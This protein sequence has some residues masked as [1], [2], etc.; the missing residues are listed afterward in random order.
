MH[1]A[2]LCPASVKLVQGLPGR[3]T[4][5]A[6]EGTVAHYIAE[7]C[8]TNNVAPFELYDDWYFYMGHGVVSIDPVDSIEAM[9]AFQVDDEMV[10]HLTG[11]IAHCKRRPGRRSVEVRVDI[12]PWTP[13]PD[14]GGTSDQTAL[15]MRG[16]TLYVDDLKYGKGVRVSPQENWQAISY[17]LGVIN[18]IRTTM[19]NKLTYIKR[20]V[21][22]IYQPRMDNI[23]EWETTVDELLE[24]G[25]YMK[26]RLKLS[27]LPD[28]P[29]GPEPKACE[30]CPV[31]RCRA[32]REKLAAMMPN[33]EGSE[34]AKDDIQKH[35]LTDDEA[36]QMLLL[37]PWY[38]KFFNQLHDY[39]FKAINDKKPNTVLRL[40]EGNQKRFWKSKDAVVAFLEKR[41]VHDIWTAPKVISPA[42]AEKALKGDAK[43]ALQQ[44]IGTSPGAPRLV[45]MNSK[46]RDYGSS[47]RSNMPNEEEDDFGL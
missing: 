29:F 7:W 37:R 6:A 25:E 13:I 35:F 33:E 4:P 2:I 8:M 46:H 20:V 40:G 26:S 16:G 18:M 30:F 47:I 34:I 12:S 15:D 45:P 10:Q 1:R 32:R 41:G 44:F 28:P 19:P 5:A 3:E 24:Y 39:L 42:K 11:Y 23:D 17:A 43:K 31:V 21:I 22:G 38:D 14:Q 36:A 27:V 9:N